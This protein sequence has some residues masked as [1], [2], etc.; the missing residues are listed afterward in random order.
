MSETFDPVD[1]VQY[2][3][4]YRGKRSWLLM[5]CPEIQYLMQ[6]TR[7]F[8]KPWQLLLMVWSRTEWPWPLTLQ[9]LQL[10]H[11]ATVHDPELQQ[12]IEYVLNGWPSRSPAKL[13]AYRQ[14]QDELSL[15]RW[16]LVYNGRVVVPSSQR[17]DIWGS[18]MRHTKGSTNVATTLRHRSGGRVLAQTSRTSLTHAERVVNID[19]L[20]GINLFVQQRC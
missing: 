3:Y 5:P 8:W 18:Y 2:M 12:V 17:Q 10:L 20:R 16:L 14:A 15:I 1:A 11:S 6:A 4:M 19:D 9:R 13:Q 7:T